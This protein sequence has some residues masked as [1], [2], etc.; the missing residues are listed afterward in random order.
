MKVIHIETGRHLYG[1]SLQV[2]YLMRGLEQHGVTNVLV[3]EQTSPLADKAKSAATKVYR[4][5]I[6]GDID[7]AFIGRLKE[8]FREQKPDLVHLHSRRG[9]EW[10]GGIAAKQLGIP[11]VLS[12]RVDNPEPRILAALKYRLYDHVISISE[13][14]RSVLAS[15]GVPLNKMSCVPSAVDIEQYSQPRTRTWFE[16][17]FG[18][19]Q[20]HFVIA[21]VAQLI[22]RKGHRYLL[23]VLPDLLLSYPHLRVIFFGQGPEKEALEHLIRQKGLID[24]VQFAGFRDDLAQVLPNLDLLVHPAEMEG[25]GVSLLQA[26]VAGVPIIASKAGG[27]PEIVRHGMTGLLVPPKNTKL[28][29]QAIGSMLANPQQAKNM[30]T[31]A[32]SLVEVAFSIPAMVQGNLAVYQ[33]VLNST[34]SN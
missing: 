34:K 21:V 13:G 22:P 17:E 25:L 10:L 3:C 1:G 26:A 4:E 6:K 12:R 16:H 24:I 7:I 5:P 32:K 30:A 14:I 20:Q 8:I 9:C 23:E 11:V 33:Q 19:T 2:Y 28:L 18:V 31:S 29:K 27:M 15:E